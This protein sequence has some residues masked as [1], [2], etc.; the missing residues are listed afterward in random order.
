MHYTYQHMSTII[1]LSPDVTQYYINITSP[2]GAI[3]RIQ[4]DIQVW[5]VQ[6][7]LTS[8]RKKTWETSR[9]VGGIG[10]QTICRC[11]TL[12]L[13]YSDQQLGESTSSKLWDLNM[14]IQESQKLSNEWCGECQVACRV[15]H[16][17]VDKSESLICIENCV[18]STGIQEQVER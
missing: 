16:T 15:K 18:V 3:K 10:S 8:Y 5:I 14:R 9:G 2:I 7:A 12:P 4:R 11:S 17:S 1:K 6:R 13:R